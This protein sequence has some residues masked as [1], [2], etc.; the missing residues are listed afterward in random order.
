M[1]NN[2]LII[3]KLLAIAGLEV[4]V[5]ESGG[6]NKGER[7]RVY[8]SATWL[9]P[10]AWPWCAAFVCW[11]LS[12]WVKNNVVREYLDIFDSTE[13]NGWRCRDA[14]AFGFIKWAEKRGVLI[15]DEKELAKAGDLVVYDFSHIGIVYEDQVNLTDKIKVIEGNTSPKTTQRDGLNDGVYKMERSPK[16]VR[17]YIRIVK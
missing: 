13:A 12:E 14:S 2:A 9:K 10:G 15:T 5:T 17:A 1:S 4:G 11:C 3:E 8:Q 6:N 16:L 7:I